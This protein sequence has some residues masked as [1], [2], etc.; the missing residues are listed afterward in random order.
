MILYVQLVVIFF[1]KK[2]SSL[3]KHS[4]VVAGA[5]TSI[6][7]SAWQSGAHCF[8]PQWMNDRLPGKVSLHQSVD[9]FAVTGEVGFQGDPG[10]AD[11][12]M[13]VLLAD[14]CCCGGTTQLTADNEQHTLLIGHVSSTTPRKKRAHTTMGTIAHQLGSQQG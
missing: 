3:A 13:L 6:C 14:Q 8:H 2:C 5:S 11:R 1:L 10:N 4:S 7:F 12:L 9:L